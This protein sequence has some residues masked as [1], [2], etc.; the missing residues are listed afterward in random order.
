MSSKMKIK[1][2]RWLKWLVIVYVCIG[3]ALYF[4]QDYF[5]F[6]PVPLARN[7]LYHFN[8]PFKETDIAFNTTDTISMVKFFPT[9]S[10]RKG[11]V[12]YFHG[13]RGN[14]NRYAKFASN[15]T[16]H[17]Y[18]VW[19]EDYPGFGKS[20]GTR[21]EKILYRQAE[22]IYALAAAAFPSNN[23]V[24]YGKSFGTGIAAYL[25]STKQ[26]RQLIL[27]TPYYSIADLFG[28]YAPVYPVKVMADY[29]IPSNEYL[30]KI[31]IPVTIFHGTADGVI[32]YRCAARLKTVLKLT[33]QFITI[34]NGTHHNLNEYALFHQ[35]LDSL[36]LQ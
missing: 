34:E 32:P 35:K 2:M 11:V 1:M 19:M 20:T 30:A 23:I 31:K 16:K 25:A 14:I 36:L 9:D 3:L 7:Y 10:L 33:D 4:L 24:V 13:N 5:L 8:V 22:Q 28:C 27:E 21:N 18:E 6:H 12:I 29:V 17:G 15:F 26:C